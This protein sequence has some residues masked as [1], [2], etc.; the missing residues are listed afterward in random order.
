MGEEEFGRLWRVERLAPDGIREIYSY[1]TSCGFLSYFIYYFV[2]WTIITQ[3]IQLST[4]STFSWKRWWFSSFHV[5]C[6]VR[7]CNIDSVSATAIKRQILNSF[8]LSFGCLQIYIDIKREPIFHPA[9]VLAS[10]SWH[11]KKLCWEKANICLHLVS[12]IILHYSH[13]TRHSQNVIFSVV[14]HLFFPAQNA[15]EKF[16]SF[17][18]WFRITCW[19][20]IWHDFFLFVFSSLFHSFSLWQ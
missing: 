5:Y 18:V 17:R 19:R 20:N 1:L 10:L 6:F 11:R 14:R 16:F 13:F 12:T 7:Q 15:G 9:P 2:Y 8:S 3:W 4:T